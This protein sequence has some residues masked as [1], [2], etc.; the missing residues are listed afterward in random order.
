MDLLESQVGQLIKR[1]TISLFSHCP[2]M[3]K[4]GKCGIINS[5]CGIPSG[6]LIILYVSIEFASFKILKGSSGCL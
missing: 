3:T 6:S 2:I 1:E 4:H 5:N